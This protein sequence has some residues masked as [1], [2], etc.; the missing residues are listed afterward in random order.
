MF[1][2]VFNPLHDI[3]ED[4]YASL[5]ASSHPASLFHHIPFINIHIISVL[6][7][8]YIDGKSEGYRQQFSVG[9]KFETFGV[10]GE[11]SN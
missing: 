1:I 7:C 2:E 3:L 11:A 5:R 10:Q 6:V 9:L 8:I 4:G